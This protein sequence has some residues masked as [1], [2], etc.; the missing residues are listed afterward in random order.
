MKER[1]VKELVK[2]STGTGHWAQG[3][4]IKSCT[5]LE[6]ASDTNQVA[7]SAPPLSLIS[8]PPPGS[9]PSPIWPEEWRTSLRIFL[10]TQ[11]WLVTARVC[12]LLSSI[13]TNTKVPA[14]LKTDS[15]ITVPASP[16]EEMCA[17][18]LGVSLRRDVWQN[19]DETPPLASL[20]D[21]NRIISLVWIICTTLPQQGDLRRSGHSS[22]QSSGGGAR[23]RVRWASAELRANSL[24]TVPQRRHNICT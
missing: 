21:S 7:P 16:P 6:T 15:L 11:H 8:S 12:R 19:L 3:R 20:L 17:S 1:N 18:S 23:I 2:C 14:D 22:G 13:G 10:T 4:E 9:F 5:Q 24:S